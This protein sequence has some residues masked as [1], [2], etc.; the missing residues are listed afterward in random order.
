MSLIDTHCHLTDSALLAAVP[1]I[2][3]RSSAK[4]VTQWITVGTDMT[5]SRLAMEL[6]QN[7]AGVSATVGVHPHEAKTWAEVNHDQFVEMCSRDIVVAVGE[8]GLDFHYNFSSPAEQYRAFEAQLQLAS[9][10]KLPVVVHTR[11]AFAQTMALLAE[12]DNGIPGVVLHCFSGSAEDAQQALD[13]GYFLSFT[14][15]VTFKNAQETRDAVRNVPFDRLMIETDSPYM[16]PEPVR[17]QRPN[18]PAFLFHTATYLA[19]LFDVPFEEFCQ[20]VNSTSL[21]F[22]GLA[23]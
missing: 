18:E 7:H 13:R 23:D 2:L 8:I 11:N 9:I 17:K 5:D 10:V 14:G 21:K 6:A 15:M 19:E 1:S 22:F 20:K 4:G 12:Y 3:Q 16:S